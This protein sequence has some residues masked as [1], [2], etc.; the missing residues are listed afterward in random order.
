MA[1]TNPNLSDLTVTGKASSKVASS[2]DYFKGDATFAV[3]A[4][5]RV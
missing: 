5:G 2:K 3:F 4:S 1:F